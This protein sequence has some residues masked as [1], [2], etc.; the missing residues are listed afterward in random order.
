MSR[1]LTTS[2]PRPGQSCGGSLGGGFANVLNDSFRTSG[3]LNDSFE[4]PQSFSE[5]SGMTSKTAIHNVRVFDGLT[6]RERSTVVID[7]SV[8]GTDASGAQVVDGD[9]GILIPGL[10]DAHI[11][12]KSRE[13]LEQLTRWGVTTGLDMAT[14]PPSRLAA[15]RGTPGLS[16]IRSAGTPAIGPGGPHARMP[17]RADDAILRT[18]DQAESFVDTRIAN[19]SDYLKIVLEAPGEGGPDEAAARAYVEA[20]HRRGKLVVAHAAALGAFRLAVDI[21]ADVVTH[22]PLGAPLPAEVV[23]RLVSAKTVAVPTLSMMETI[24]GNVGKPEAFAG[25]S[26]SVAALHAAGVPI[27]AGTDANTAP[28]S[29]AS[30]EHGRSLHHELELLVQAGLSALDALRA[31]TSLPAQH[32]GLSDRG[33]ITPGLRA[34]LVLVDGDP[35]TEISTT[36]NL[37]RIWC[38]GT[39]HSPA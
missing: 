2:A 15:L 34:D 29:P 32:F 8:I 30:V 10:I 25:A 16:D 24:A 36:R 31:A 7:G 19:G 20:A 37:V 39:A 4:K 11:H 9:G 6:V 14:W 23:A 22:V 35:T 13:T 38:G 1:C 33:A 28:G 12:L 3:E 27:L 5:E 21:G 26:R 17:G 18:T